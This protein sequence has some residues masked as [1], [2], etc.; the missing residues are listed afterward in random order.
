MSVI[1]RFMQAGGKENDGR[2]LQLLFAQRTVLDPAAVQR[3]LRAYHP[4]MAAA[5]CEIDEA[6]AQQGTPMGLL[7]W[8]EHVVRLVGFDVPMPTEVVEKCLQP[9]HFS[10]EKK[11]EARAHQAHLLLNYAGEEKDALEQYVALAA[12]SAALSHHGATFILNEDGHTAFP[13]AALAGLK[14]DAMQLLRTL[15]IPILYSG[16]VKFDVE[17]VNGTW[18]RTFGNHLLGLPDFAYLAPGHHEGQSTFDMFCNLLSY[19][20]SSGATFAEGHTTQIGESS[21]LRFRAPVKSEY[22]LENPK[23]LLV[24]E[25][26]SK[27]DINRR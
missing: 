1:E 13:A 10:A 7:S 14:G 3:S 19:L 21:F 27:A 8:G 5:I 9:A 16:F 26:I 2:A 20:R 15:P 12:A 22:F 6:T 11:A 17:G 4:S 24:L 25:K 18:M 23:P